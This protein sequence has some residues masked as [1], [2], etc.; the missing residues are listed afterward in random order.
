MKKILFSL[1]MIF[2]VSSVSQ[3]FA[4]DYGVEIGDT[5][6]WDGKGV[7]SGGVFGFTDVNTGYT[8]SSFC[9]E[10]SQYLGSTMTITGIGYSNSSNTATLTD[11]VAWLYWNFSH[12]SLS[13]YT[14]TESNQSDLQNLIWS[15]LG[16]ANVSNAQ[17]EA[18]LKSATDATA[19]I[20]GWKNDGQVQIVQ[21]GDA[22]DGLIAGSGG[23]NPVPEPSTMALLG[24]GLLGLVAVGRKKATQN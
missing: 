9:V 14:G 20:D 21:F 3:A 5:V 13:G 4:Y 6:T 1:L 11:E 18:W 22:Q 23:P 10:T 2:F 16:L 12:G 8:W 17:I 19:G 7:G 24:I 15:Q